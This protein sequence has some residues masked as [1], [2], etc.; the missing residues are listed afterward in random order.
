MTI[1][2]NILFP[3]DFSPSCV[4]MARFVKRVAGVTSAKVTLLHV[5]GA[6]ASGYQL[7]VRPLQEVEEE[8]LGLAREKLNSFLGSEFPPEDSPRLVALG[9][10]AAAIAQL[11][12][13]GGFD[14]IVMPTHGGVF[15]RMLLGSTTAKVL[16]DADCPVLTTQ[17][18]ET[19]A[20]RPIEHRE[21]ICAIGLE[22]DSERVLQYA[23]QL[24]HALHGNLSLVHAIPAAEL[25]L[26]IQLD[27]EESAHSVQ[28][29]AARQRIEELQKA[30]GSHAPV[31]IAAGPIKDAVIE[32]AGR[33]GAD[34]IVVG[35]SP[36]PG[37]QGRL[38]D[39]TYAVVRD[40]PCPVLSV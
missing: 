3:V 2:G 19:I 40:A 23:S 32:A 13:E 39:L 16:N 36:Q 24:A 31:I 1:I 25:G 15:R 14:L 38:R 6:S 30:V 11:A 18:A 10:A 33:V 4:A 29:H 22:K 37:A 21:W 12:K 17:H 9:D 28:R 20:P 35:R 34:A 27:L 5:L 26:P 7:L 8:R